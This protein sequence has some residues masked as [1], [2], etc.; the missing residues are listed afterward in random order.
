MI[1]SVLWAL[2]ITHAI[3]WFT[4]AKGEL[5][6]TMVIYDVL[7][8]VTWVLYFIRENMQNRRGRGTV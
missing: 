1:D 5:D 7:V 6:A 3:T 4:R 2:Y 8:G